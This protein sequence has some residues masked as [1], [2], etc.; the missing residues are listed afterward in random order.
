[1]SVE[2]VDDRR[3]AAHRPLPVGTAEQGAHSVNSVEAA[4]AAEGVPPP[5]EPPTEAQPPPTTVLPSHTAQ[6]AASLASSIAVNARQVGP[7]PEPGPES[8]SELGAAAPSS[9]SN[10]DGFGAFGA[11]APAPSSGAIEDDAFGASSGGAGAQATASAMDGFGSFGDDPPLQLGQFTE[12][13][14]AEQI[15]GQDITLGDTLPPRP[16]TAVTLIVAPVFSK[17]ENDPSKPGEPPIALMQPGETVQVL[18]CV[19]DSRGRVKIQHERGWTPLKSPAGVLV[20]DE[21]TAQVDSDSDPLPK[22]DLS[23]GAHH[24]L[25]HPAP[26][27]RPAAA[28]SAAS[29]VAKSQ[30]ALEAISAGAEPEQTRCATSQNSSPRHRCLAALR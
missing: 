3:P 10:D 18:Q 15:H 30:P 9:G 13:A 17:M 21:G 1:M 6:Q 4:L 25:G 14:D 27:P 22:Q 23:S 7:E 11:A 29:S 8:E 12:E 20:L 16:K 24:A 28:D 26:S 5:T 2:K 19:L